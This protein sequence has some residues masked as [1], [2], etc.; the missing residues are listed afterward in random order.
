MSATVLRH[1]Y[2][3]DGAAKELFNYRGDEILL[4]G[5]AGTGKSRACLEKLH[6]TLLLN[7]NARALAVRKTAVSLTSTGLVTFR[8]HVAAEA[9]AVGDV[10]W[11]GGSQQEPA[12]YRYPNGSFL[13]VGGMDKATKIMSSEY[14]MIYVQEATELTEND[15]E[16]L[17]TRLRN[18]QVRFQQLLAD[19]NPDVPTHWLKRRAD[20]GQ[21]LMLHSRHEDN[22]TLFH[23]DGSMTERGESYIGKL[24]KLTGV[25]HL[26]LRKGVWAAA[27]GLVYSEFDPAI[28]LKNQFRIP[29]TWARYWSI[30]FGYNNPFVCQWWAEDGDGRLYLYREIYMTGRIVADHAKQIIKCVTRA[31]GTWHEPFPDFIVCDHDA[32]GRATLEREL[33]M[34]TIPAKKT[35][36]SG[37]EA[38]E[39]RF[40]VRDDGTPGLYIV[41]DA[42][43]ER[44]H[45]LRDSGRPTSTEEEVVG[46]VWDNTPGKP[47]KDSPVKEDDHGMD[48]K[49][50]LVAEKDLVDA[51][52]VRWL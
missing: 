11:Y 29:K 40:K 26:R 46:Y 9:I 37:I 39:R 31:D 10:V 33:G 51:T 14:D 34:A 5:P 16:A 25:R 3:P 50:Y 2:R 32:E 7:P 47:P 30:D 35:V 17:T 20:H 23:G 48:A 4:S 6:L 19:C 1:H 22:P 12:G 49:R 52:N 27:E 45:S 42:L 41:R 8:E 18:G 21:T 24:D 28:H 44:D 43:V 13:A 36:T 15:W 38:V